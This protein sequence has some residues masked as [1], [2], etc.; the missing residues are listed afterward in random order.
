MVV[1]KI[2]STDMENYKNSLNEENDLFS[3]QAKK[4]IKQC[5]NDQECFVKALFHGNGD[6]VYKKEYADDENEEQENDMNQEDNIKQEIYISTNL[7]NQIEQ[8]TEEQLLGKR[9]Q[10]DFNNT[11]NLTQEEA[12]NMTCDII[13]LN[14]I[15]DIFFPF[16]LK[17]STFSND[18]NSFSVNNMY[19]LS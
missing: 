13:N 18:F 7:N 9:S 11:F 5:I 19:S 16:S 4:I 8:E 10:E 2:I 17:K 1:R 12:H 15:L 14:N 6:F 3:E